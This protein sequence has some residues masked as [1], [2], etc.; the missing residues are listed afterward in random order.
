MQGNEWKRD[1]AVKISDFYQAYEEIPKGKNDNFVHGDPDDSQ[2]FLKLLAETIPWVKRDFFAIKQTATEKLEDTMSSRKT[3]EIVSY[4]L[5]ATDTLNIKE[6]LEERFIERHPDTLIEK[7]LKIIT[8]KTIL[9]I[10][11][12]NNRGH[13]SAPVN[14]PREITLD[15]ETFILHGLVVFHPGGVGHYT[16]H[17]CTDASNNTWHHFNDRTFTRGNYRQ[18]LA[19]QSQAY[20]IFYVKQSAIFE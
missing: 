5:V 17:V 18:E 10:N 3:D 14:Y 19:F 12:N 9:A 4:D 20:L 6:A 13:N 2:K 16:A 8:D 11:I 15:G 1:G 7:W